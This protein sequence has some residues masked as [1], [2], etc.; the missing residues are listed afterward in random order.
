MNYENFPQFFTATILEWQPLLANDTYKEIIIESLRYLVT[1]KRATIYSFVIMP[2]H[3]HLIW[4]VSDEWKP[5]QVQQS[6]LKYTAQ[7]IKFDLQKN[8][9]QLLERF[10]VNAA[11]REYQF[12]ERNALSVDLFS[13]KVFDQKFDYIHENPIQEK[14]KLAVYA[15][16][17]RWSSAKFY[18]TG[19]DDFDLLTHY[20]SGE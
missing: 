17:Y 3:I 1:E 15:E 19:V 10:K 13:E 16:D 7:Q 4:Q 11:D 6:F 12:W 2:N 5:R 18:L 20:A 8:D 9:P 14:W